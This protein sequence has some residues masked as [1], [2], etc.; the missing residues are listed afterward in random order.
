MCVHIALACVL[1]ASCKSPEKAVTA[2]EN[3]EVMPSDNRF[4]EAFFRALDYRNKGDWQK[5]SASFEECIRLDARRSGAAH[6]ELSRIDRLYRFDLPSA[7]N[8]ASKA[9]ESE[10]GNPWYHHE[11]G[12]VYMA[13]SKYDLAVKEYQLVEKLNPD[14]PNNLYEQASAMLYGGRVRDAIEVYDRLEL[15]T[16]VYEELSMQKHQLYLR[17]KDNEAAGRELEKLAR[18]TPGEARHWGTALRFY[19]SAGMADKASKALEELLRCDPSD[20]MVRFQLAEYYSAMGDEAR[21]FDEMQ[22]AF[23]TGDIGIDQKIGVLLRYF[24]L[25]ETDSTLLPR[26]YSLLRITEAR[27]PSEAKAFAISGDFLLRDGKREEALAK[28]ILASELDASRSPIWAQILTISAELKQYQ[29]LKT[30]ANRAISLFPM[31]PEYY[32]YLGIACDQLGQD[33]EAIGHLLTG[34]ELV[35]D[36]SG[37]LVQFCST[38]GSAYDDLRDYTA[39]DNAFREALG[40]DPFNPLVLNNYAYSLAERK[41]RLT[42]AQE[43]A[44]KANDLAPGVAT[45]QD[46]YAWVL[47]Q[48]N[49]VEQALVWIERAIQS[50]AR[51]PDLLEHYG[52]I[53]YRSGRKLEAV[54]QWKAALAA[55]GSVDSL[56][57]K[58]GGQYP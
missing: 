25:S 58:I 46:T 31:I 50:G 8:H 17:L 7:L 9:A 52:D 48:S 19:T 41:D 27:H 18:A 53:L 47:F 43:M 2:A 10:P 34:R 33:E 4:Q 57:R 24:T 38:L 11:L 3:S 44:K 49:Q 54:E 26:A 56:T 6:Y 55:G 5:A 36:D 12:D 22:A 35:I 37:L 40:L 13:M 21:A 51:E 15:Q 16:G 20:G 30:Q 32:L 14:D 42:E 29:G 1:L 39:S 45:F 23:Q 28:F